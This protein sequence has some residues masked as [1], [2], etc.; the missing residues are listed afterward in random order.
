MYVARQ[1]AITDTAIQS[2][3]NPKAKA[4]NPTIKFA[5]SS[6]RSAPFPF[7]PILILQLS[8]ERRMALVPE[9]GARTGREP[10]LGLKKV[11]R[12]PRCPHDA[13][14]VNHND[15][16]DQ[17]KNTAG[18]G[19]F[20]APTT[21]SIRHHLAPT[22][23]THP[24]S[25]APLSKACRRA[26]G[27]SGL[28]AQR[29][30]LIDSS[31]SRPRRSPPPPPAMLA[32]LHRRTQRRI[33]ASARTRSGTASIPLRANCAAEPPLLPPT[34][35]PAPSPTRALHA[36][37]PRRRRSPLAPFPLNEI[38]PAVPAPPPTALLVRYLDQ[39]RDIAVIALSTQMIS[40][41]YTPLPVR[42]RCF[43]ISAS[44]HGAA[45]ALRMWHNQSKAN[46]AVSFLSELLPESWLRGGFDFSA[47]RRVV[48]LRGYRGGVSS[49]TLLTEWVAAMPPTYAFSGTLP[50]LLKFS[51][52][53]AGPD[54]SEL[55]ISPRAHA[56]R[57]WMVR[58]MHSSP[59]AILLPRLPATLNA[60]PTTMPPPC[61]HHRLPSLPE[62]LCQLDG[63]R[64]LDL[65]G[66]RPRAAEAPK[67]DNEG[68]SRM[69][70]FRVWQRI[71]RAGAVIPI[72]SAPHRMR[73]GGRAASARESL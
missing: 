52:G 40:R 6:H 37:P 3:P 16:V 2:T 53:G 70:R 17:R 4:K 30:A 68:R 15:D 24:Q 12:P 72:D 62:G 60:T 65:G 42:A 20:D 10:G 8:H 57:R 26:L 54:C 63:S 11:R 27:A 47:Q 31:P 41:R 25:T 33:P 29:S 59:T 32:R 51:L 19:L 39:I 35:Y 21:P 1:R 7:Y 13:F 55:C 48:D 45:A 5:P 22:S 58:T 69:T 28:S 67:A 34:M 50:Q 56:P 46:P 44:A 18:G 71:R 49:W 43:N 64:L 73:S 14:F 9:P 23:R 66:R 38:P 36:L 61:G